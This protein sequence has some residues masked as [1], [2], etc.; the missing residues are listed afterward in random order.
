MQIL[1]GSL[2]TYNLQQSDK[3]NY[4][5]FNNAPFFIDSLTITY[6][7]S[8]SNTS[9]SLT[10]GVDYFPAF[11]FIEGTAK[12]GYG[13]YGGIDLIDSTLAGTI[14]VSYANA[15]V[16]YGLTSNQINSMYNSGLE[17]LK[18][19]WLTAYELIT[20]SNYVDIPE[21]VLYFNPNTPENIVDV[22][23][24]VNLLAETISSLNPST[25][26]INFDLHIANTNNPHLDNAAELGLDKVPNWKVGT[27]DDIVN[28]NKNLFVTPN[29]LANAVSSVVPVA[30]DLIKGKVLLNNGDTLP[31]D[32]SNDSK[33]LTANGLLTILN[34]EDLNLFQ[35]VNDNQRVVVQIAPFPL[36]YP[37]TYN[38]TIINTFSEFITQ[39]QIVSGIYN[40]TASAKTGKIYFPHAT[41]VPNLAYT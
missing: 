2:E 18:D 19:D 41:I 40:L 9:V 37:V 38:N 35:S 28:G 10:L 26:I 11:L 13:V 20:T 6:T 22:N 12:T 32:A 14:T 4:V 30:T 16:G 3:Y 17:P 25:S 39:V 29:A 24:N 23:N 27:S 21:Q 33:V 1:V 31:S 7:A 5:V 15:N 8:N 34:S 36:L